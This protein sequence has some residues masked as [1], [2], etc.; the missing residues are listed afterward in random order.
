MVTSWNCCFHCVCRELLLV[1]CRFFDGR[2]EELNTAAEEIQ[3][4]FER[5]SSFEFQ[6]H[7]FFYFFETADPDHERLLDEWVDFASA[8]FA[9]Y[10][11]RAH[12]NYFNGWA[13][14]GAKYANKTSEEQFE[15]MGGNNWLLEYF[16]SLE[17]RKWR[18]LS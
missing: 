13:A 4:K 11:A 8:L 3:A 16:S 6:V 5:D 1:L 17:S 18:G 10:L 14:R 9:P 2:F 15:E 12:Y 7:N